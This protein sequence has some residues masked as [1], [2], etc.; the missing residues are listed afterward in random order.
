MEVD[1]SCAS[2]ASGTSGANCSSGGAG[3]MQWL[4]IE[5]KIL[6]DGLERTLDSGLPWAAGFMDGRGHLAVSSRSA[7]LRKEN[8]Y[9]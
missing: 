8:V 6:R 7:K 2:A 1:A 4:G 5:S 9:R 3:G